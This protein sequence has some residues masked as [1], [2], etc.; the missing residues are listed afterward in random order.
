MVSMRDFDIADTSSCTA[1]VYMLLN[2]P[3]NY[4]KTIVIVEG[5]DD[6]EVYSRFFVN[7]KTCFYPDGNCDKHSLIL[8][9]LNVRYESRLVA[10]KDADFDRLNSVQHGFANM[11]LSDS[12]D[13]EG[14]I[15]C[16]GITGEL[17]EDDAQRCA[18]IDIYGFK[19]QLRDISMLKWYNNIN[20]WGLNFK[21]LSVNV[22][23]EEYWNNAIANT[24]GTVT[25]TYDSFVDFL[26]TR[27]ADL[28]EL[29]NGHD[30]FELTYIHAKSFNKINFPK[31]AFF[32]RIRSAYTIDCFKTTDL[33]ASLR[34]CPIVSEYLL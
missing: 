12:H 22:S 16:N 5:I 30:L 29:T 7:E 32:K 24:E 25:V 11:F 27:Q 13:L 20:H 10:I 9:D 6:V 23:I 26:S 31:K 15:L 17:T 34:E 2:T 28:N 4:E 1:A 14:M 21:K 18:D 3:V 33:Y 19:E 8:T